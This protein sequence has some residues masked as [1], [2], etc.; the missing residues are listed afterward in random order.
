MGMR[1]VL[2]KPG[3]LT[4]VHNKPFFPLKKMGGIYER[5]KMRSQVRRSRLGGKGCIK[6][7]R[8]KA[9]YSFYGK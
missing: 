8:T 2:C 4:W 7:T 5:R 1:S 9:Q 3:L 6:R